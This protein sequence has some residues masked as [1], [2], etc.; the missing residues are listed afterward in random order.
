MTMP[1][2]LKFFK[3]FKPLSE[4]SLKKGSLK[5]VD[6]GLANVMG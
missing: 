3:P 4:K 5:M 2:N 6:R 1:S